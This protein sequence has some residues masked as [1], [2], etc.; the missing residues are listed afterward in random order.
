MAARST[1]D[2]GVDIVLHA[3]QH[4]TLTQRQVYIHATNC[5]CRHSQQ[6]HNQT[7]PETICEAL[8]DNLNYTIKSKWAQGTGTDP[9]GLCSATVVVP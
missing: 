7:T 1:A 3:Q 4:Y 8:T 6:E 5:T 2:A 9:L